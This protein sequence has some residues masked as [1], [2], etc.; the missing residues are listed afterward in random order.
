VKSTIRFALHFLTVSF[1]AAVLIGNSALGLAAVGRAEDRPQSQ[2]DVRRT[3]RAF[4]TPEL[5]HALATAGFRVRIGTT[6]PGTPFSVDAQVVCVSD[7]P[8]RVY[9]YK[10]IASRR[11]DSDSIS[12]DGSHVGHFIPEWIGPPHFFARGRLIVLTLRDNSR[13]LRSLAHILGPTIN[14]R[15]ARSGHTRGT[16]SGELPQ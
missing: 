4:G 5:L 16:C 15:A 10:D 14:P 12:P 2:V 7:S 3:D 6:A 11:H 1:L 9:Q 13:L 8:L